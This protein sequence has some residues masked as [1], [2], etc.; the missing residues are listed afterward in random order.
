M[1]STCEVL[2]NGKASSKRRSS[3]PNASGVLAENVKC[4][5]LLP[6]LD[7]CRVRLTPFIALSFISSHESLNDDSHC[8]TPKW[9][10][11]YGT[12]GDIPSNGTPMTNVSYIK[13]SACEMRLYGI[14]HCYHR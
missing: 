14:D 10:T 9:V 7:D 1:P 5:T 3:L 13:S 12:T 8:D 2:H 4:R 11:A 6:L